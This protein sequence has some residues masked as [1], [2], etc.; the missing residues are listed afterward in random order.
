MTAVEFE[1]FRFQVG[2]KTALNVLNRPRE[3]LIRFPVRGK[4]RTLADKASVLVQAALGGVKPEGGG[5]VLSQ[6]GDKM[7]AIANRVA[8]CLFDCGLETVSLA[9]D[10]LMLCARMFY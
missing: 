6:E 9:K 5:F 3:P 8:K 1:D 7:C 4:V 10:V 2:Q